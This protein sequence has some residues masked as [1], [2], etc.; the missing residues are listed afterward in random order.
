M[1]LRSRLIY[2]VA[3]AGLL[4]VLVGPSCRPDSS[5]P[6]KIGLLLDFSG[7]P[8]TSADRQ[9]GFDLAIRQ[10]NEGGGVLGRL[11][12]WSRATLRA[13]RVPLLTRRGVWWRK[14]STPSWILV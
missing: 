1:S 13:V 2:L 8:E 6:M 12:R 11:V 10:I 9:L 4:A 14:A 7:S 3:I 5:E